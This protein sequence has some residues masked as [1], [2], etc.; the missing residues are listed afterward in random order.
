MGCKILHLDYARLR[1]WNADC[2]M[3]GPALKI[4][5]LTALALLMTIPATSATDKIISFAPPGGIE[6]QPS[7]INAS[8]TVVGRYQDN[9][10]DG[11]QPG[12]IRDA[13][14]N[15][16]ALYA[17]L[18]GTTETTAVWINDAGQITG[19]YSDGK[20]SFHGFLRDKVG[21]YSSFDPPGSVRTQPQSINS[22]GQI[23]GVYT[24]S[25][26]SLDV[27]FLREST[28][29]FV[30]FGGP[31]S[32]GDSVLNAALSTSGEIAGSCYYNGGTVTYF[33]RTA[34]G[35][36]TEYSDPFG[37]T[38]ISVTAISDQDVLAGYYT[39]ASGVGHGFWRDISGVHSFDYPGATFTVAT[40]INHSGTITGYYAG[41]DAVRHG[42]VRD[43]LG[44]FTSFDGPNAE[45]KADHGTTPTAI[46]NSGQ[47]TGQFDGRYGVTHGFLRK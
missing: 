30:T 36:L 43:P 5:L 45:I 11:I 34:G 1:V 47:I 41:A 8:G 21:N 39:D 7:A 37:G 24:T 33:I 38:V 18:E 10:G 31:G 4:A 28:G 32:C 13:S 35:I 29:T 42:F 22:A 3:T 20:S 9:D 46:N 15:F 26:T 40:G 25:V 27:G 2:P 44:N 14:G 16:T 6:T 17:P 23:S 12:F 19:W